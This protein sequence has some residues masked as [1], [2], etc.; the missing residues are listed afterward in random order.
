MTMKVDYL[1]WWC[2][3]CE[4]GMTFETERECK[5]MAEMHEAGKHQI[6]VTRGTE[7]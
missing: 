6:R 1:E 2:D 7:Q 4:Y 3:V 5:L